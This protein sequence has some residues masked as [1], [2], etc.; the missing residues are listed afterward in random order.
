MKKN[1]RHLT[2][3]RVAEITPVGFATLGW[4]YYIIFA[5][6]NWFLIVPCRCSPPRSEPNT[7]L[8]SNAAVYFLFPETNGR[9]LEEVDQIFRDSSNI[10]DPVKMAKKLPATTLAEPEVLREKAGTDKVEHAEKDR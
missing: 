6:I 10:F 3:G 1:V 4:R 7:P 8:T 2:L 9:H 5:C